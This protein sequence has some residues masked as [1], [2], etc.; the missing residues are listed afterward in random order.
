MNSLFR[1][2]FFLSAAELQAKLPFFK[3]CSLSKFLNIEFETVLLI[4]F[5]PAYE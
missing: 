5:P 2:L 3:N 1:L 4:I